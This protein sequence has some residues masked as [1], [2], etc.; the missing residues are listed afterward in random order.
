MPQPKDID[1]LNGY[2]K[3]KHRYMLFTRDSLQTQGHIQTASE[4]IEEDITCKWKSK[5]IMSNNT[6][7]RQNR[8]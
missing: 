4:K 7:I 5:E 1:W 8:L 6:H 2:K 3:T